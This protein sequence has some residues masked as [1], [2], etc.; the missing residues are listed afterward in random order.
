MCIYHIYLSPAQVYSRANDKEPC[1]WWLAKVRMVKGEVSYFV[2][3]YR[4]YVAPPIFRA[5]FV[6]F[7]LMVC[8]ACHE[9]KILGIYEPHFPIQLTFMASASKFTMLVITFFFDSDAIEI[10]FKNGSSKTKFFVLVFLA[11]KVHRSRRFR[12]SSLCTNKYKQNM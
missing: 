1:G 7:C 11:H 4:L 2:L 9:G 10:Y 12:F 8:I 3:F 6:V 5:A